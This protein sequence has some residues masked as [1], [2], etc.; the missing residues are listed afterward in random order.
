MNRLPASTR[1]SQLTIARGERQ[2]KNRS[3]YFRFESTVV[4]ALAVVTVLVFG[5]LANAVLSMTA[6]A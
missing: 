4:T 3:T 2:M 6:V 1:D 5:I